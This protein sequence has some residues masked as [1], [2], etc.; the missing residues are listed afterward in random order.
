M[1]YG[2]AGDKRYAKDVDEMLE[3]DISRLK[4]PTRVDASEERQ[5]A[6]AKSVAYLSKEQRRLRGKN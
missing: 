4:N 2:D 3:Y 1:A 6:I 5:S